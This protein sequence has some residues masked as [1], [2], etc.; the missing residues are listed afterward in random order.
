MLMIYPVCKGG[1]NLKRRTGAFVLFI[2]LFLCCHLL[3]F[4]QYAGLK[5]TPVNT[6]NLPRVLVC[7]HAIGVFLHASG[8]T[9]VGHAE[10]EDPFG[11]RHSPAEKAG[12]QSGDVIIKINNVAVC[13]DRQVKEEIERCG[14]LGKAAV[15]EIKRQKKTFSVKVSPVYCGETGRYRIGLFIRDNAAGMGTLSF[16]DPVSK[17][18]GALGHLV[19]DVNTAAGADLS[20]GKIVGALVKDISL[21]WKGRPG[22]KIGIFQEKEEFTGN[23]EANTPFGIIGVLRQPPA[24]FYYPHPLPVAQAAEI[25]PGPAEMLTVLKGERIE[26]FSVEIEKVYPQRRPEGKGL[27]IKVTDGELIRRAGGIVQGMS[28][29]PIIQNGKFIGVVTHVFVNDPTRGYGVPAEWMIDE[30][31]LIIPG[32]NKLAA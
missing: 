23:I 20:D 15:L 16:Y 25:T 12:I 29:S 24:N 1:G 32:G 28:G 22:E 3:P 11:R 21:G 9:V 7:G 5:E 26:R 4:R 14:L 2:A 6:G 8:V 13:N 19:T 30:A 31:G 27:V 18:Y 17:R 10:V